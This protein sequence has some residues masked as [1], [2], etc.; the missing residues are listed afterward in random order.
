MTII[1]P[2]MIS[3]KWHIAHSKLKMKMK[4][5]DMKHKKEST[6]VMKEMKNT[7]IITKLRCHKIS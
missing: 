7:I 4:H 5:A 2:H 1:K 6:N 3:N